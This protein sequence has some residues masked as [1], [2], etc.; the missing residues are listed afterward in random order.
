VNL[1]FSDVS[2]KRCGENMK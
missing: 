1:S 2:G